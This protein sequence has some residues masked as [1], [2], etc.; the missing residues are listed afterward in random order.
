MGETIIESSL[1]SELGV[2]IHAELKKAV[3][4]FVMD[5]EMYV[6][7]KF[8][9]VQSTETKIKWQI[10]RHEIEWLNN[11]GLMFLNLSA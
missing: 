7:Y 3:Q 1:S 9:P 11:S 8:T 4:A 2:L 5:G 10:F 6:L